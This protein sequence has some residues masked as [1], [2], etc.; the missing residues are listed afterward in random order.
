MV[1]LIIFAA[2][3]FVVVIIGIG[4]SWWWSSARSIAMNPGELHMLVGQSTGVVCVPIRKRARS[5]IY[6]FSPGNR[7]FTAVIM[8]GVC[9]VNPASSGSDVNG[10]ATFVVTAAVVGKGSLKVD[11]TS[12]RAG[13]KYGPNSIP[14]TVYASAAALAA[15]GAIQSAIQ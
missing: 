1:Q 9:T 3:V 4:L 15:A 12:S 11:A 6:N 5:I 2:I 8:G 13:K 10:M 7:T 14:I